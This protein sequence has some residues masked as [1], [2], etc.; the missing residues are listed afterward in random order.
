[1][2]KIEIPNQV[3]KNIYVCYGVG[4]FTMGSIT[5][6]EHD[7]EGD[8]AFKR[9]KDFARIKLAEAEITI[10]IPEQDLS[11]NRVKKHVLKILRNERS[12]IQTKYH[13]ELKRVDDDINNLLAIE[14]KGDK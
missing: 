7:P 12:K 9:D 3:T 4:R 11:V 2:A 8:R 14:Y 5:I 10:D 1:M 13:M 6:E